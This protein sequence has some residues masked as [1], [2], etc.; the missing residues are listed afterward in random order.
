MLNQTVELERYPSSPRSNDNR[1]MGIT[2]EQLRSQRS[3]WLL[4]KI[5]P[6][7]VLNDIQA[8]VFQQSW[9]GKTYSQIASNT[10]YDPS[11]LKDVGHKLWRQLSDLLKEPVSKHN[12]YTVLEHRFQDLQMLNKVAAYPPAVAAVA[13]TVCDC[14]DAVTVPVFMG[15]EAELMQ[16]KEWIVDHRS[17][18]V[19]IFGLGGVGKT[20]LAIKSVEQVSQQF[21][22][23]FWRSLRNTPTFQQFV[24]SLLDSLLEEPVTNLP[25]DPDAQVS[26]LLQ[27]LSQHRCLL[28]ID[29]WSSILRSLTIAGLYQIN[30][31][32]YGLFLRRISESR[33]QSCVLITSREQPIGLAF[34]NDSAFPVRSLH[35]KG[36]KRQAGQEAL[37][38]FG[39]SDPNLKVVNQLIAYYAGNLYALRVAAQT[40]IDLLGGRVA[41]FMM[42]HTLIYGEIR[43]LLEQQVCRLSK[44]EKQVMACIARHPN[45][46][47]IEALEQEPSLEHYQP[48]LL[49]ALESLYHRS[50]IEKE[51]QAFVSPHFLRAYVSH[52]LSATLDIEEALLSPTTAQIRTLDDY[53][54]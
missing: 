23:V 31:E 15:R 2:V 40:I 6:D 3:L 20:A 9:Q 4:Q 25:D 42:R 50:F 10:R 45:S 34:K 29:D 27:S 33:H 16:L 39:V 18:L 32:P 41:T 49:E 1:F 46:I 12:L 11:Y 22:Y 7:L 44:L 30:C 48:L 17:C 13:S 54:G 37:R 47:S 38:A 35:L 36:L 51:G 21:D 19:G 43:S 53:R 52:Q 26:L 28:V 24:S 8:I 5:C 14:G